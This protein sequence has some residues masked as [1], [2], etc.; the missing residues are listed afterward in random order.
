[1][2]EIMPVLSDE[3]CRDDK[4]I[5]DATR[6]TPSEKYL[7]EAVKKWQRDADRKWMVERISQTK[8]MGVMMNEIMPVIEIPSAFD[9][10]E[11]DAGAYVEGYGTGATAQNKADRKSMV[12]WLGSA[13]IIRACLHQDEYP[14]LFWTI[15]E[16]E[17][18]AL[19]EARDG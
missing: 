13:G 4:Q 15:T 16:A 1:M 17:W 7:I 11:E 12:G 18:Q 8:R 9:F 19:K 5:L 2:N 14:T 3:E 10:V 6:L